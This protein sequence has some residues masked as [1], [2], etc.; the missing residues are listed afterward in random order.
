MIPLPNHRCHYCGEPATFMEPGDPTLPQSMPR[1]VCDS[2]ACNDVLC[3]EVFAD[4][5]NLPVSRGVVLD[6]L[7]A[8]GVR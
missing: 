8:L 6:G 3:L 7:E 5:L 1:S 4:E 2:P